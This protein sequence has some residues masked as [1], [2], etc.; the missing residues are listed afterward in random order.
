VYLNSL[1][2][3]ESSRCCILFLSTCVQTP[4]APRPLL[5]AFPASTLP[6]HRYHRRARSA[7]HFH[8]TFIVLERSSSQ[9]K[10][11]KKD[12]L[13]DCSTVSQSI[14]LQFRSEPMF[15]IRS[16]FQSTETWVERTSSNLRG[17]PMIVIEIWHKISFCK[18]YYPI[19]HVQLPPSR[20]TTMLPHH[21]FDQSRFQQYS[22]FSSACST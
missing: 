16:H 19:R 3:L 8:H 5:I 20:F 10:S 17:E 11:L 2:V 22:T 21:Q 6:H 13:R 15:P 14:L 9:C 4:R 12:A 1:V 7:R 18:I